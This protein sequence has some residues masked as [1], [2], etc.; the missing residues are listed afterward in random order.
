MA[1][2]LI[3]TS[4]WV[5]AHWR[6]RFYPKGL[7]QTRWLEYYTQHFVTVEIN[8]SFY[9]LPSKEAFEAWRKRTP[10]DFVF[11]VKASR[12]ITHLKRLRDTKPSLDLFM[13]RAMHLGSKLGPV[14]FQ[15]PPRFRVNLELLESFLKVLPKGIRPVMEFRD[16]SWHVRPV[17]DLLNRYGVAY[18][19]MVS[20]ELKRELIVT[21]RAL[22][23]R[24]HSPGGIR[25][26]FG[27]RRLRQWAEHIQTLM[28]NADQG[29]VYFN[30]DGQ[31]A[32][33]DDAR[34]LRGL[35]GADRGQSVLEVTRSGASAVR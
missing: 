28:R 23:I 22:Y 14:L 32:A 29:W 33:I 26:G 9:R 21:A 12:Y 17:Y 24:F 8:N 13:E 20:P 4:G 25:P 30:N 6:N 7:P 19:I 15:L 1:R 31:G 18:C 16:T 3:G 27:R 10:E 34:I 35:L 11:A 5:Y 2:V